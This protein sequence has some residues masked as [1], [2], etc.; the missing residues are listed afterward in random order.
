MFYFLVRLKYDVTYDK[1]A[2]KVDIYKFALQIIRLSKKYNDTIPT[3]MGWRSL[4]GSSIKWAHLFCIINHYCLYSVVQLEG[5]L[6]GT[7]TRVRDFK[8]NV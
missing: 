4:T 2:I 6:G 8:T 5:M 1:L 7:Y 3:Y